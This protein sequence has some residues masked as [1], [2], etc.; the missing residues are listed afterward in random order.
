MLSPDRVQEFP[1]EDSTGDRD[2]TSGAHLMPKPAVTT[3]SELSSSSTSLVPDEE[4]VSPLNA[5]PV[6]ITTPEAEV[7]Q[8]E[9]AVSTEEQNNR[10]PHARHGST[11]SIDAQ[12]FGIFW[13]PPV[14]MIL[15]FFAGIGSSMALHGYYTSLDGRLVGNADDQQR[16]LQVG[17]FLAIVAQLNIVYSIRTAYVQASLLHTRVSLSSVRAFRH[18][19]TQYN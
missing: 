17:T 15:S 8:P 2:V 19:S 10:P 3:V 13:R 4:P 18:V 1:S 11:A 12:P 6:Q 5:G 14:T 9:A 7:C 16:S